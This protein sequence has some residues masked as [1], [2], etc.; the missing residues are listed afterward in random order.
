[1]DKIKKPLPM[2]LRYAINLAVFAVFLFGVNALIT[3][4][5]V[6]NYY[7]KVIVLCGINIMAR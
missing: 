6:P 5:S 3:G 4:G 7:T 1:M 2:P